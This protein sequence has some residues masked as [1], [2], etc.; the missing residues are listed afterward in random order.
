[1]AES[2]D[3]NNF[4]NGF[5]KLPS[6][7]DLA[8]ASADSRSHLEELPVAASAMSS[9]VDTSKADDKPCCSFLRSLDPR[10]VE[11]IYWRDVKKTGAVL[12]SSAVLLLSLALFSVLSVAAYLSLITLT[13]TLSYR[14]YRN[15]LDAVQ[16]TG[17]GHP[18]QRYLQ[19][20]ISLSTDAVHKCSDQLATHAISA[21]SELRRLFL[22]EDMV[23]SLKFGL[24][25]WVLTYIGAWFNGITLVI[26]ADVLLFSVPKFYEVY[27]VQI[28]ENMNLVRNQA[29]DVWTQVLQKVPA[30]AKKKK[31]T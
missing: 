18:F 23:D 28:N 21:V 5:E 25:L 1:M 22:V 6:A 7:A 9:A 27:K 31:Q 8:R 12:G 16:K 2:G 15:V 14:V 10:V 24:L 4:D 11:L 3:S 29:K 13:V 30:L 19:M 20:D 17:H 26:I